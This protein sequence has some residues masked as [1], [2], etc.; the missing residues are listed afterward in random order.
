MTSHMKQFLALILIVALAI[1]GW[2]HFLRV[3]PLSADESAV[4]QLEQRF[5]AASQAVELAKRSADV[6]GIDT[7]G[8]IESARIAVRRVESDLQVV[9]GRLKTDSARRRANLLQARIRDF[10]DAME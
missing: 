1:F 9:S 6:S 7:T 5:D 10:L 8:D 2:S 3:S 4:G